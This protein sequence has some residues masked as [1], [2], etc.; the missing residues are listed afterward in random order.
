MAGRTLDEAKA[1]YHASWG[2]KTDTN[3]ATQTTSANIASTGLP[4]K[5]IGTSKTFYFHG[6]PYN[7]VPAIPTGSATGHSLPPNNSGATVTSANIAEIDS[8]Y[9]F[10]FE[11]HIAMFSKPRASIDWDKDAKPVDL[12]Q[13]KAEPVAFTAL[14]VPIHLLDESPF[15]LDTGANAH[16]SPERSDFKKLR[17]ISPHPIAGL[18][19]PA[20]SLSALGR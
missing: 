14:H 5:T 12:T 3:T 13:V 6:I 4:S 8:D 1:A 10:K 18:G 17:P 11:A 9:D 15:F 16:I 7:L 2:Q 20:S 19:G